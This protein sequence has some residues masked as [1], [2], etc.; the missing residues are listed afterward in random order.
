[1][2]SRNPLKTVTTMDMP[3]GQAVFD[4]L[5]A[6]CDDVSRVLRVKRPSGINQ[7]YH[8]LRRG[9]DAGSGNSGS[10]RE[11]VMDGCEPTT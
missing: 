9:V 4:V 8:C 11:P 1:M 3:A 10:T 6:L 5:C 7:H 2:L